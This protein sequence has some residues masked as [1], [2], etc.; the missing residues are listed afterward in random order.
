MNPNRTPPQGFSNSDPNI[1]MSVSGQPTPQSNVT[2]RCNSKRARVEDGDGNS[3]ELFREEIKD[4]LADWF[5]QQNLRLG[6]LEKKLS[7]INKH[8]SGIKS[9]NNGIEKSLEDISAQMKDLDRKM[10]MLEGERNYTRAKIAELEERS[11]SLERFV[12]K[13]S[14]EIRGVPKR[15]KEKK[16][17]LLSMVSSLIKTTG[18]EYSPYD[19]RDIYRLP[20]KEN[21][22]TSTIV[23][24][25][26]SNFFKD[27][28]LSSVKQYNSAQRGRQLNTSHL[29]IDG[30]EATLFVS[31]H[32]TSKAK[33]LHF[34][35]RDFARS[36]QF[37][38]CWITNGRIF[39]RKK[40]GDKYTVVRNEGTFQ[41]LREMYKSSN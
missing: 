14:V 37:Q 11:E 1:N 16:E 13:T 27:K 18:L 36:E 6:T 26:S 23:T 30:P 35:A 31:E 34:L 41:N 29:G 5:S 3:F 20:S 2:K 4:L 7:E 15:K 17:E 9:S 28:F 33:R 38:F 12:R 21:A 32:L 22:T 25:F 10:D 40:E 19:I 8:Y 39:L 24:E